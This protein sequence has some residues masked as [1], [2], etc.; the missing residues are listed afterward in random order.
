MEERE[1]LYGEYKRVCDKLNIDTLR[2]DYFTSKLSYGLYVLT[3]KYSNLVKDNLAELEEHFV[4]LT[5]KTC[6]KVF[7]CYDFVL[8]AQ[9]NKKE[10]NQDTKVPVQETKESAEKKLQE[11]LKGMQEEVREEYRQVYWE[12]YEIFKTEKTYRDEVFMLIKKELV[13]Q[14]EEQIIKLDS[15]YLRKLNLDLYFSG[16]CGFVNRV[17]DLEYDLEDEEANE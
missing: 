17:Y 14:Y 8:W 16:A 15:M 2:E 5:R 13:R 9:R 7:Q 11:E 6:K 12:T 1:K 10:F 3:L 4:K